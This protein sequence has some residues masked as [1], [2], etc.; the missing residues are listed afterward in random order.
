MKKIKK[1]G[2][3]SWDETIER[4]NLLELSYKVL[5]HA[6]QSRKVKQSK[7]IEIA[8]ALVKRRIPQQ[9][10]MSA[11]VKVEKIEVEIVK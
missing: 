10:D 5:K 1:T 8:L 6:L 3:A 9:V 4:K 7:K 2:R 11:A